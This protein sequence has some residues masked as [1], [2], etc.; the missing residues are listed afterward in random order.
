MAHI[1]Q[2]ALLPYSAQAMF[3]LVNDIASYPKFMDGCLGAEVLSQS[4]SEVLA[5]LDLGK[6]GF[7]YSFSTKNILNSPETMQMV[8]VD[9]PFKHFDACWTFDALTKDACKVSLDMSFEFKSGLLD[10]ALKNLFD[11]SCKN[12]V[13]AVCKRADKLYG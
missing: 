3:D 1:Q 8:L 12:L 4:E 10:L 13:N 11:S 9:G 2:S 5:R 6:A 7:K